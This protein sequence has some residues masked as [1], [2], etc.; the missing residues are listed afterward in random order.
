[1]APSAVDGRPDV[2][3]FDLALA[4]FGLRVKAV[5]VA[6]ELG[7]TP[8]QVAN[9]EA[10]DRPSAAARRRYLEALERIRARR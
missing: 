2:S 9:W 5:E 10:Q 8:Q 4:R 1:M 7:V 3:G 6:R